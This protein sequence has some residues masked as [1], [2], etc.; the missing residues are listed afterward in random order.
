[1]NHQSLLPSERLTIPAG[2][3][4]TLSI[5]LAALSACTTTNDTAAMWGD[6]AP[7]TA[8]SK[9][10]EITPNTQYVNVAQGDTI[11]FVVNGKS[12]AWDFDGRP[13]GYTFNLQQVAPSGMLDHQVEAYVSPNPDY[14]G[15]A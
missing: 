15:G 6:P 1:M 7:P 11:T 10:I 14:L 2:I 13:E 8:A 5:L 12:F 9:T 3:L 4:G